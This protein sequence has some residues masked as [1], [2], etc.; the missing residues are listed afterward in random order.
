MTPYFRFQYYS[1]GKKTELDARQYLIREGE[2]DVETQIGKYF[3]PTLQYQ[4]G[5]RTF[6]DGAKPVNRQKG[7]LLR[8]QIQFNY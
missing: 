3:E 2:F 4:Y 8:L 6:Q 5:D 1:G 7:S